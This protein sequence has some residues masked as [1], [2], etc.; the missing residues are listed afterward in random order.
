MAARADGVGAG[1]I[2]DEVEGG[3]GVV[4]VGGR[5]GREKEGGGFGGGHG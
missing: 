2:G 1:P 5:G 4:R 3:E